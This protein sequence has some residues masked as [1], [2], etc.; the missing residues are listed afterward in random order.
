MCSVLASSSDATSGSS[1]RSRTCHTITDAVTAAAKMPRTS[2]AVLAARP[3]F[4]SCRSA[5]LKASRAYTLFAALFNLVISA[6]PNSGR[7]SPSLLGSRKYPN[8]TRSAACWAAGRPFDAWACT[9]AEA[10]PAARLA[11]LSAT[12]SG[13]IKT[14]ISGHASDQWRSQEVCDV[15]DQGPR[16][17]SHD[18]F[19]AKENHRQQIDALMDR[20]GMPEHA[21]AASRGG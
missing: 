8:N 21:N 1:L 4:R 17:A 7:I 14:C 18:F 12:P 3:P 10:M 5:R 20:D 19:Q 15:D 9:R 6:F 13:A 2:H 16:K 11:P